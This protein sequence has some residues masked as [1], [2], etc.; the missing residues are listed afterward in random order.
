MSG[1]AFIGATT[2]QPSHGSLLRGDAKRNNCAPSTGTTQIRSTPHVHCGATSP[3]RPRGAVW[4]VCFLEV[5]C[6]PTHRT[7]NRSAT[8]SSYLII[9]MS[10]KLLSLLFILTIV[11]DLLARPVRIIVA[12]QQPTS[13]VR[14]ARVQDL[15][16]G[17]ALNDL[18]P[19]T[20][21]VDPNG[22]THYTGGAQ[23]NMR[24][25]YALPHPAILTFTLFNAVHRT[26]V[27]H[28][29][30]DDDEQLR[31]EADDIRTDDERLQFNRHGY[32]VTVVLPARSSLQLVTDPSVEMSVDGFTMQ[33]TDGTCSIG[34]T[35]HLGAM[36]IPGNYIGTFTVTIVCE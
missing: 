9:R 22:A 13:T 34:A 14:L 8:V 31:K 27:D 1:P 36:Q 20:V 24:A 6:R 3:E 25:G 23:R 33:R 10:T 21:V 28:A 12:A 17:G 32:L 15:S 5:C 19:G 26:E 16:F 7:G 29:M 2:I 11:G 35:L 4:I 18:A 30:T